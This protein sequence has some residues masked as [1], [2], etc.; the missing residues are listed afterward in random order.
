MRYPHER[1]IGDPHD[2]R[3]VHR[4]DERWLAAQWADP[5]SRA[6]V[7]SGTRVKPQDG[8]LTWVAPGDA[9]DGLRLLLG[10]REGM[11]WWTVIVASDVA[12]AEPDQWFPL[13][14]LL[15]HLGEDESV[16]PLVFH[17]LGMAEW[18][19][20]T[21]YCPRCA[22]ELVARSAGHE[23]VCRECGKAQFPR[24]DPA[25][26]MLITAGEPGP[27]TSAACSGG[28]RHGRSAGSR[29]WPGSVSP[30]SPWRTP[31]AARSPRRPASPSARSGT[32]ATS[33][34]RCPAA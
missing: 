3:G 34:G 13:R 20:A 14:G 5:A 6:L 25:V 32:S 12:A 33:R 10:E 7:V 27:R 18:H 8:A 2:R 9:P 1:L 28:T 26:I 4:R 15:P 31:Y 23:L 24:L 11:T 29:R 22:G 30:A 16:A 19:W 17:A 21:R